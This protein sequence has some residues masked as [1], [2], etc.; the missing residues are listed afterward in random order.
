MIGVTDREQ[1]QRLI[2]SF[3]NAIYLYDDKVVLTFNYKDVSKTITL[4]DVEQA[5]GSDLEALGYQKA[6]RI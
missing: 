2:D 4:K 3:I 5:F 1:R 6:M